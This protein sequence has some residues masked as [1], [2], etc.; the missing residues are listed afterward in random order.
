VQP[1]EIGEIALSAGGGVLE[2]TG[3]V[4]RFGDREPCRTLTVASEGL[5]ARPRVGGKVADLDQPGAN[6]VEVDVVAH[7]ADGIGFDRQSLIAPLK[8]MPLLVAEAVETN[9]EGGLQPAHPVDEVGLRCTQAE[10]VVVRHHTPGVDQP[11]GFG[12]GFVQAVQECR[13]GGVGGED[14]GPVVAPSDDMVDRLLRLDPQF[15][16]HRRNECGSP[17]F[18]SAKCKV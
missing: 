9:R 7:G 17:G 16:S 13:L 18:A 12:A 6:R 15:A 4:Q 14:V 11:A 5:H 2:S 3:V 8:D 10:M 1:I